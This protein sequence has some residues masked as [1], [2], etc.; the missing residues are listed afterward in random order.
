[1]IDWLSTIERDTGT[2]LLGDLERVGVK[3]MIDRAKTEPVLRVTRWALCAALLLPGCWWQRD[4]YTQ[5]MRSQMDRF[6]R[7]AEYDR[8]L[9]PA[10]EGT[11]EFPMWVR[12][13]KLTELRALPAELEGVFLALFQSQGT[14]PLIEFIVIGSAGPESLNEFEQKAFASLNKGGK[15]PGGELKRQE[16]VAVACLHGGETTFDLYSG[17]AARQLAGAATATNYQWVCYFAEEGSQ[18]NQKVMLAFI[19]PDDQY[20]AFSG[21]MV[22]CLESLAL[23]GK[24]SAARSG[25]TAAPAQA[26][27]GAPNF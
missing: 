2:L 22:K 13:P 23:S 12:P 4:S 1:M 10:F 7:E 18:V 5:R 27:T 14:G 16:P 11:A 17:G 9:G 8:V 3:S 26:P 15:G 21:A 24:V 6:E 19:V 25:V 20:T